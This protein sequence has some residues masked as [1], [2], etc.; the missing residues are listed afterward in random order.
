MSHPSASRVNDS[1]AVGGRAG[2]E[3]FH[4]ATQRL[5][6]GPGRPRKF[7]PERLVKAEISAPATGGPPEHEIDPDLQAK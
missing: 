7:S 5:G 2:R 1:Q 4:G 3:V 6:N